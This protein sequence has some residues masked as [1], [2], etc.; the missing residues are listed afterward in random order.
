M[1]HRHTK[2][3]SLGSVLWMTSVFL[4][5]QMSFADAIESDQGQCVGIYVSRWPASNQANPA[6]L[7]TKGSM[8]S[9]S[10][11]RPDQ[12]FETNGDSHDQV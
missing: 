2:F 4:S 6:F 11:G 12:Y 3:F 8:N 9:G 7:W 5:A 1:T 10:S